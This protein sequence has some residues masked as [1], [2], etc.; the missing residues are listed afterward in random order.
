M[1]E[2]VGEQP[3]PAEAPVQRRGGIGLALRRASGGFVP[4]TCDHASGPGESVSTHVSL[5]LVEGLW[6]PPN[7]TIRWPTGSYA[8]PAS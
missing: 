2:L 5:R 3:V 6:I 7:T 8:A 1:G 4:V